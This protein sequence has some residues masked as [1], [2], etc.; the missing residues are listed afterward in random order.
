M[1]AVTAKTICF[2]NRSLEHDSEKWK[3]AFRKDHA[4]S[5]N[6]IGGAR[7]RCALPKRAAMYGLAASAGAK[8]CTTSGA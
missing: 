3:P 4:P 2:S 8:I 5:G 7:E 6:P 1:S